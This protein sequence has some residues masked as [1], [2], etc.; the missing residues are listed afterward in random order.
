MAAVAYADRR[1]VIGFC[2]DRN[3]PKGVLVFARHRSAK[4]LRLI[5]EAVAR[6]SYSDETL[7]VPGIIEAGDD[8]LAA[9]RALEVWRDWAWSDEYT[10]RNGAA[11]IT[12]D[13]PEPIEEA[14]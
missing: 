6:H 4:D 8:D 9:L 14:A 2:E 10:I 12:D 13:A 1:G 11:L 7:L 3:K 5:V